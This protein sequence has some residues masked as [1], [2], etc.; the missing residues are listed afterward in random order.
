MKKNIRLGDIY[1]ISLP[2][3]KNAYGRLYK[4]G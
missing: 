3:G 2:N 4:D 1:E